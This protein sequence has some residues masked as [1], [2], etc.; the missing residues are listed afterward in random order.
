[1]SDSEFLESSWEVTAAA[2]AGST[3]TAERVTSGGNPGAFRWMTHAMTPAPS[4]TEASTISVQHLYL[5]ATY[6]PATQGAIAGI[7]YR[8]DQIEFYA[9]F[10]G[11]AVG[12]AF[13]LVQDGRTHFAGAGAFAN[14]GWSTRQLRCLRAEDF[15]QSGGRYPDFS[16]SGGPI[17]FGF[18]RSNTNGSVEVEL[19]VMHGIDGWQVVVHPEPNV[20][21]E[22]PPDLAIAKTD[23]GRVW[24]DDPVIR[25][26]ITVSN[27]GG[28]ATG[29]VIRDTVPVATTFSAGDSTPGWSCPAGPAEGSECTF[30][31]GD[32]ASE[33][34]RTATFAVRVAEGT[35]TLFDV[36]N[37]VSVNPSAADCTSY[38]DQ[39]CDTPN[40]MCCFVLFAVGYYELCDDPSTIPTPAVPPR[41]APEATLVLTD[42]FLFYRLRDRVFHETAGG[43]RATRLYYQYNADLMQ[44]ALTDPTILEP[45]RTSLVAWLPA[46]EALVEGRGADVTVTND[47]VTGLT[48]FL[49][50]LRAAA[51]DTLR[52]AID[53][54]RALVDPSSWAGLTMEQ[55]LAGLEAL[56]CERD[57]TLASVRCRV[58]EL[59]MLAAR[60]V[61][62]GVLARRLERAVARAERR[63]AAAERLDGRGKR[64]GARAAL[65]KAGGAVAGFEK[66]LRGKRGTREID[67]ELRAVLLDASDGLRADLATL[68]GGGSS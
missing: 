23:G 16:A 5:G 33:E 32:L 51:G 8:E 25:Y 48:A 18:L 35:D 41:R 65:R 29:V 57:A 30:P 39:V 27:H 20:G 9:P 46:L 34:S 50:A 37:E 43:R 60:L 38:F 22:P 49:E 45:A 17:R 63:V 19:T 54:E 61:P 1:V 47:Q 55:A 66:R 12:W 7:D 67:E 10:D 62:T 44:A 11:A 3:Q 14:L 36:F 42:P 56:S 15:T 24:G 52:Q 28:P 13:M 53:R 4:E 6:D 31:V 58:D 59:A 21:C 68:V 26:D 40:L 64:R 2:N